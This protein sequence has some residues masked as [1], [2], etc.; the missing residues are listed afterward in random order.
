MA[1]ESVSPVLADRLKLIK[2]VSKRYFILASLNGGFRFCGRYPVED[3]NKICIQFVVDCRSRNR[4]S[5]GF[6]RRLRLT[7]L[8]LYGN[9]TDFAALRNRIFAIFRNRESDVKVLAAHVQGCIVGY[10]C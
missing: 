3:L 8:K 2:T 6:H 5:Y 1:I 10:K 4:I 9:G 7:R